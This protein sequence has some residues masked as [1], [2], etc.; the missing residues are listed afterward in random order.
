MGALGVGEAKTAMGWWKGGQSQLW[1]ASVIIS[2]VSKGCGAVSTRSSVSAGPALSS[3]AL[4]GA[5]SLGRK[6]AATA[7]RSGSSPSGPG[8]VSV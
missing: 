3:C 1:T 8:E 5:Q 4:W 7:G 6:V 2:V